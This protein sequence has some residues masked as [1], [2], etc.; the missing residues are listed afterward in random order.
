MYARK[1]KEL[2]HKERNTKIM[3]AYDLCRAEGDTPTI[4]TL[5]AYLGISPQTVRNYV[6]QHTELKRE[7]GVVSRI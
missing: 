1:P 3:A 7:N 5:A 2:K 4:S 6:D